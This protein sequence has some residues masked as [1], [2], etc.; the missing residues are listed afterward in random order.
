MGKTKVIHE[1]VI[2]KDLQLH[3]APG[4]VELLR[5]SDTIL[6]P[7]PSPDPKG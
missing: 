1:E 6:I 7:T 3:G 5:G 4:D 2:P